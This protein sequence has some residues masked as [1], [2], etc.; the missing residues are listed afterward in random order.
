MVEPFSL[1][2]VR[3]LPRPPSDHTP[4]VWETNEGW[5]RS[6]YFKVD[7]SWLREVGLKEEVERAWSSHMKHGSAIKRL[8]NK[9]ECV[10]RSLMVLQK[11][12]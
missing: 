7:K 2:D 11:H 10:R 3:A 5:R 12:I 9:I 6:T 4:I 8:A 1:A